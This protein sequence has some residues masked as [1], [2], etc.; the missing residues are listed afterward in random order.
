ME[1]KSFPAGHVVSRAGDVDTNLYKIIKGKL[2]I[3]KTKDTMVSPIAYLEEGSYVGEF[4]YFDHQTRSAH[5]IC[6]EDA[7]VIV[8]EQ[9]QQNELP[10]W[11][12]QTFKD[13]IH[14]VRVCDSAIAEKGVKRGGGEIKPLTIDEQRNLYQIITGES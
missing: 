6:V 3:C 8:Y 13:L 5:I 7:E 4:S 9:D 14:K 10:P 11:L 2:L 12:I 1:K